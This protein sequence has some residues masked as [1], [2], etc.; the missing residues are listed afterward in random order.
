MADVMFP[1]SF[2]PFEKH[3]HAGFLGKYKAVSMTAGCT[4][5]FYLNISASYLHQLVDNGILKH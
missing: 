5:P 4:V 1:G 3:H 2:N